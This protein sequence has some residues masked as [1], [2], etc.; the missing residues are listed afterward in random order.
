LITWFVLATGIDTV[1]TVSSLP[2]HAH[3]YGVKETFSSLDRNFTYK[4]GIAYS[5]A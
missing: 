4:T 5:L 2:A 1:S 3:A